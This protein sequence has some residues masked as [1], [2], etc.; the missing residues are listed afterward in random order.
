MIRAI[1]LFMISSM[2]FFPEKTFYEKPEDYKFQ[3]ENVSLQTADHI[4]LHG[5]WIVSPAAKKIGA[6]LYLHGNAGNI[7]NRLYKI[8]GWVDRGFDVL[9]LDYR[10]YG[11]SAGKITNQEDVVKDAHAGLSWM[12]ETKK[13][14]ASKTVLYGESLGTYPAIRLAGE[15]ISGAVVLE[16]PFTSFIE[17]GR[18]HYPFVPSQLIAAFAF[19]NIDHIANVKAPLFILHGTNDEICPYNMAGELFEKAPEPK[20]FLTIP[21]G[22][23]NDLPMSGGEDYWQKPFEFV[24]KHLK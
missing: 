22:T 24:T 7:S 20:G 13:I 17:L 10:G 16:A 8:K 14:S 18:L 4:S 19:P 1:I 21:N 6:I 3:Y 9:L 12:Q 5:W 23:H 11:K 15:G 2:I